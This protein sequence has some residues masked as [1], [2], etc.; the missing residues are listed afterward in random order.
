MT[1]FINVHHQVVYFP[2]VKNVSLL[3]LT[4]F[5][6]LDNLAKLNPD[7]L[8]GTGALVFVYCFRVNQIHSALIPIHVSPLQSCASSR[9][10]AAQLGNRR[11]NPDVHFLLAPPP[12]L[13]FFS[14]SRSYLFHMQNYIWHKC[15]QTPFLLQRNEF[16]SCIKRKTKK[17]NKC[18]SSELCCFYAC[19]RVRL[20]PSLLSNH[21]S[22]KVKSCFLW[23][24][25]S[26]RR[27]QLLKGLEKKQ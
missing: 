24:K 4:C 6:C 17:Q 3:Y 26:A 11:C 9:L 8:P 27:V 19:G 5:K 14:L 25:D 7:S 23:S 1:C 16:P 13:S 15:M 12:P 2:P 18:D 20:I 10:H 22:I 21:V